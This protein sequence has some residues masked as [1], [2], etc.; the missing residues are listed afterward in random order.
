MDQERKQN[1]IAL[2]LGSIESLPLETSQERQI[3]LMLGQSY[4]QSNPYEYWQPRA[5]N[6]LGDAP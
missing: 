2:L 1:Q 5:G 6:S 3:A 4:K